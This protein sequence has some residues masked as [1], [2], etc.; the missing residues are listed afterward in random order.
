MP[1]TTQ[2]VSGE[3]IVARVKDARQRLFQ[4][5]N[6]TVIGQEEAIEQIVI[7]LLSSGHA[8]LTGVPGLGKTL[9]VRSIADTFSLTF[10]R[11]QFTPDLMPADIFG[12]EIV[13][14]DPATGKRSFRFVPG[15]VFAN[16]LLAD[17]INRTPPKTQAALLEAMEERQVT[18]AGQ[19]HKLQPPF[20]VLATQNPI[21][22]EGTYPLPEAQLDRFLLNIRID[23]LP[24][25][26]EVAMVA[27]TTA[28]RGAGP[29]AVFTAEEILELQKLVRSVPVAEEVVRYAVRVTAATRPS[30]PDALPLAREKIKWGAGS[31]ASQALVLAGKARALLDGRYAVAI[32]DIRAL[33]AP[34]LRHRIIPNFHAEAEGVTSDRLIADI[35]GSIKG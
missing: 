30:H 33:A 28:P 1:E 2:P 8:L 32:D 15:P 31:R 11:I 10:K 22:L 6:R 23:Y 5:L 17:E 18:A 24:M 26:K 20:F 3:E 19:T 21:E 14:E 4:E 34:V 9:L 35:L 27:A 12:T 29:Q 13:E 7:S 25:E 16:I